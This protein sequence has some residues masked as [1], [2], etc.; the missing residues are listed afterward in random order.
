G[1][2]ITHNPENG[3][4]YLDLKKDIDFDA[5]IE[6]RGNF[7][8][9][10]DLNGFFYAALQGLLN[11]PQ[12][13]YVT[14]FRIWPYELPWQE[15]NVT[16]PGYLFLSS[17]R[18]RSTAQPPRDFYLYFLPP[19]DAPDGRL[20]D[21]ND[22]VAFALAGV[23]ADFTELVRR[24]AGAQA[25]ANESSNHRQVY[26]EKADQHRRALTT[27]LREHLGSHLRIIHGAATRTV[28]EVLAQTRS[29]ASAEPEDLLRL[30]ADHL[31][32]PHFHE[33]YPLYP[34]FKRLS[35]PITEKTR[36]TGA[37]E[38]ITFLARGTRTNL[39]LGVLAGLGLLDENEKVR[40]SE[41]LYA[42]YLLG[43]LE[44][45]PAAQVIN[46][47]EVFTQVASAPVTVYKDP[48]F[49][50]EPEWVAA[51]L[52]ALVYDGAITLNLGSE[53]LDA[54][55][56]ARAAVHG[57]EGLVDFRFYRRPQE[58]PLHLWRQIFEAMNLPPGL[59]ADEATREEAVRRLQERVAAE[60]GQAARRWIWLTWFAKGRRCSSIR[61]VG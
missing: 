6:E 33:E 45:K 48:H 19:F 7:L 60:V 34:A 21:H 43:L 10:R 42:R 49:K 39:A 51:V 8:E 58:L 54:G 44:A 16:R 3:Q 18:E 36:E 31:L 53:T 13:S 29:S 9:T 2:Y 27:W 59:V 55:N 61:R 52:L 46:R 50:L 25:L 5:R 15:H 32:A 38:A 22:E 37:R 30:I 56:I 24:F 20:E 28:A 1:Q 17:P 23:G 12:T 41:S 14:N 26:A 57:I 40:P 35:Q 11:L 4:Y 47:G